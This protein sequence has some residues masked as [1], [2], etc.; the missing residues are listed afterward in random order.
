M[1]YTKVVCQWVKGSTPPLDHRS[2]L[3]ESCA[4]DSPTGCEKKMICRH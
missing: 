1:C 4:I 2:R 3:P